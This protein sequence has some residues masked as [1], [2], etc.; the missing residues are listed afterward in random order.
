MTKHRR[1]NLGWAKSEE[2]AAWTSALLEAGVK[3]ALLGNVAQTF[4]GPNDD[5]TRRNLGKAAAFFSQLFAEPRIRE[6]PGEVFSVV[7]PLVGQSVRYGGDLSRGLWTFAEAVRDSEHPLDL[8]KGVS[9][10]VDSGDGLLNL[11][12]VWTKEGVSPETGRRCLEGLC[13]PAAQGLLGHFVHEPMVWETLLRFS[14][15]YPQDLEAKLNYDAAVA[16]NHSMSPGEKA[17]KLMGHGEMISLSLHYGVGIIGVGQSSETHEG[18]ERRIGLDGD[19]D[20]VR[21]R[22]VP[23]TMVQMA[24]DTPYELIIPPIS[25]DELGGE[26]PPLAAAVDPLRLLAWHMFDQGFDDCIVRVQGDPKFE[27]TDFMLSQASGMRMRSMPQKGEQIISVSSPDDLP[28]M[29]YLRVRNRELAALVLLS[30][31]SGTKHIA[32]TDEFCVFKWDSKA[33][34]LGLEWMRFKHIKDANPDAVLRHIRSLGGEWD[35]IKVGLKEE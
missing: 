7:C 6:P 26:K 8:C 34:K 11:T 3:P 4:R 16:A 13:T 19:Y 24:D 18:I 27:E 5:C 20:G 15:K 2:Y 12:D 22:I 25:S 14:A 28:K 17:K 9:K 35:K 30:G 10:M 33:R 21:L 29:G 1:V 32:D 23:A 31:S